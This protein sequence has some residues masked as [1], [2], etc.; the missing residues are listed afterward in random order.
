MFLVREAV[1]TDLEGLYQVA[2]YLDSVN[3]PA[4]KPALSEILDVS[5]KSFG[6]SIAVQKRQYLFVI[7]DCDTNKVVGSSMVYAQHGQRGRP[8]IYFDVFD[9]ERYSDTL[10]RH[11]VHKVLRLGFNYNGPTEI[12][13]LAVLPD[14]RQGPEKI[15]LTISYSRFLFIAAHREWF[16][17]EV[18]SELLPP[19]QKG[20]TSPLW[21]TLGRR[22]TD[23]SYQEA[24]RI[25]SQNK[26]FIR[27]LF[28]QSPI[29]ATLLPTPVQELIGVVGPQTKGVE[30]MLR[31]I[32]FTYAN[33]IDPFDGGP[34]FQART[35][36][37]T[38]VKSARRLKVEVGQPP[39]RSRRML[40][41]IDRAEAPRFRACATPARIEAERVLIPQAALALLG[42]AV[43]DEVWA[44][45][46][47]A[48]PS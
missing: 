46:I 9:E 8:H 30:K 29:Y 27:G 34:H 15:G 5:D 20:G 14:Y 6:A 13:G 48:P 12:G 44:V 36:D 28:P 17:D 3:L 19:L 39:A 10:D 43:D 37:I 11:F 4:D 18:I 23:L 1:P 32:G 7:E 42:V 45:P 35:D 33:R 38:I 21:E 24:D 31:R 25:S 16:R 2:R 26:E 40:V 47:D 41:A 22:F